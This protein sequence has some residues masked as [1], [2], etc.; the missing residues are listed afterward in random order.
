MKTLSV[1]F[2]ILGPSIS[3]AD[4]SSGFAKKL[5]CVYEA[6]GRVY[7]EGAFAIDLGT[8]STEKWFI[9]FV[10]EGVFEVKL[11]PANVRAI[12][13]MNDCVLF[14]QSFPVNG[15]TIYTTTFTCNDPSANYSS[16]KTQAFTDPTQDQFEGFAPVAKDYKPTQATELAAG[17][18]AYE[19]AFNALEA[20]VSARIQGIVSEA[21]LWIDDMKAKM[22]PCERSDGRGCQDWQTTLPQLMGLELRTQPSCTEAHWNDQKI[23][24]AL[25]KMKKQIHDEEAGGIVPVHN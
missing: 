14:M 21:A 11:D 17:S 13:N 18:V 19:T 25:I 1:L 2:A 24:S 23:R 10:P 6:N 15:R 9:V 16:I 20:K 8:A 22:P 4:V 7:Q 3:H 5:S 12:P